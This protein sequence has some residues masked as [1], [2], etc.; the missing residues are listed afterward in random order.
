MKKNFRIYDGDAARV[1]KAVKRL[2]KHAAKMGYSECRVVSIGK[3]YETRRTILSKADG[4]VSESSY[5]VRVCNV[6]V[7]M[8]EQ[9][10]NPAVAEWSV[11]GRVVS[12]E[13]QVEI[14]AE[15]GKMVVIG[16]A[17]E[18]FNWKC[19]TCAHPL[20]QAFV[21]ENRTDGRILAVGSECL[22][23]YT[24]ADGAAIVAAIEFIAV[25][26]Y[27]EDDGEEG[28]G[29]GGSRGSYKV[30]ELEDFMAVCVAVAARDGGY[31]KRW[32]ES[33]LGYGDRAIEN[34]D[35]TRNNAIA[36][37][38]G[39]LCPKA[40]AP[41]ES[42]MV[43][44]SRYNTTVHPVV[45]PT[46]ADKAKAKELIDGWLKCSIPL[47]GESPDEYVTQCKFLAE[48]GWITEKTAGVAASMVKGAPAP[49]KD[50]ANS[51]HVG[52]VG[53]RKDFRDLTVIMTIEREGDYGITTI[54]KFE[55]SDGN[56][57][58]WFASG[59]KSYEKGGKIS[60]KATVKAHDEF[61]GVKQTV[62]TRAKELV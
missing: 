47:R 16:K 55:D 36:Q 35:C 48:R 61:K 22:K 40:D 11:L 46:D 27:N 60:L 21:V 3:P 12:A 52:T 62:I 14:V 29:R 17:M 23:Q 26:Q 37:F 39:D 18:G 10:L 4:E 7:D 30:I 38:I 15:E 13:G 34:L 49:K 56:I 43:L 57:L 54:L 51:K 50:Y 1:E 8:P 45:I 59:G 25:L 19:Q 58:T 6:E 5:A 53:E 31:A 32:N 42:K 20:K 33:D 28:S 24:G 44:R 2:N 9:F 41:N